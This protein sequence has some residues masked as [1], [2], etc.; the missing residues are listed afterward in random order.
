[1]T[2]ASLN[3]CARWRN[4]IPKLK[5]EELEGA[6]HRQVLANRLFFKKLIEYIAERNIIGNH[7]DLGTATEPLTT[8]SAKLAHIVNTLDVQASWRVGSSCART[9]SWVS[10]T[11]TTATRSPRAARPRPRPPNAPPSND[12]GCCLHFNVCAALQ[13]LLQLG[14]GV[15]GPPW[16][17]PHIVLGWFWLVAV[18]GTVPLGGFAPPPRLGLFGWRS[19]WGK[20]SLAS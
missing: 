18:A 1:V 7:F 16:A 20:A 6:E 4:E 14:V 10:T 12:E 3:H 9:S 8:R 13:K 17:S 2:Y 19:V 11:S 5:I 15:D